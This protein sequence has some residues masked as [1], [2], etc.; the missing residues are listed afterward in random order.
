MR[1]APAANGSPSSRRWA[2]STPATSRCSTRDGAAPIGWCCRSSSTRRSSRRPRIWPATR[3][4]WTAISP[5]RP[6]PAPTSRSCPP[7]ARC[8]RA[9]IRRSCSVREL[10]KGLCGAQPPGALRRRRHRGVQA[11]QHRAPARRDLRRE[12]LPAA[13]GDPAHGRRSEH[14]AGGRRPADGARAR[15]PGDVV[16]QQVPL[17]RRAAARA[18]A[19]ARARRGAR[20]VRDRRARRRAP[21]SPPRAP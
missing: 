7:T 8:T 3:A 15:R 1:R 11:V 17:A 10:E 13:G 6:P 4:T 9:A 12:G 2:I 5:R 16:A 19:V 21:W 14:A 20:A 18:R